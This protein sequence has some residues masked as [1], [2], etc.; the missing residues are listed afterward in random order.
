MQIQTKQKQRKIPDGIP[1]AFIRIQTS[2]AKVLEVVL[3]YPVC[4]I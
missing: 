1:A 4:A 2:I 3:L